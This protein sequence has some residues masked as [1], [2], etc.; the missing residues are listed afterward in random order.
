MVLVYSGARFRVDAAHSKHN[1]AASG[2]LKP[3]EPLPFLNGISRMLKIFRSTIYV[4]I[5]PERLSVL[6]IGS[7]KVFADEPTIAIEQRNGKSYI[8]AIGRQA[9]TKAG[10]PNFTIV[11]GFKHPRTPIADFTIA[12]MTLKHFLRQVLPRSIFAIS[13]TLVMHPLED[14]AGDLTQ[15]EIRAFAELGFGAGGRTVYVWQGAE[16]S[17]AELRALQFLPAK[18]RV[19]YP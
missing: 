19:L 15:V 4:R 2:F 11:N 10:P 9:D 7:G 8:A 16:L 3:L 17:Q 6:H 14:Y 12:E 5:K 13:P 1:E 18:G